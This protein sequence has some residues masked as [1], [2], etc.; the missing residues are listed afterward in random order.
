MAFLLAGCLTVFDEEE[1]GSDADVL[2][3]AARIAEQRGEY[4]VAASY[5]Q[6]LN[7]QKKGTFETLLGYARNLRYAGLGVNAV[8]VLE[9]VKEKER[10]V[11]QPYLLELGKARIA[12]RQNDRAIEALVLA[13]ETKPE[14]WQVHS[15]LGI[16]YDLQNDPVRAKGAY[17]KALTLSPN[18]PLVLNNL[19]ISFAQTGALEEAIKTLGRVPNLA[20]AKPQ[21]RQNLALFYGIKGDLKKAESYARLDLNDAMV[22]NNMAYFRLFQEPGTTRP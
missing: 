15:A 11:S 18:N 5:Y 8:A 16:A 17:N 1:K 7:L 22:K 2:K 6:K 14:N 12:A 4:A 13:A 10:R 19:A 20:H 9:G 3:D 21:I